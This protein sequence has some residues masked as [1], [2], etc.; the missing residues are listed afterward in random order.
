LTRLMLLPL[1]LLASAAWSRADSLAAQNGRGNRLYAEGRYA[2]A[3][4]AYLDAEVAHPGRP[5]VLY[6]LGNALLRQG[7]WDPA[8][9]ALGQ[10]A[11]KG[12]GRVREN[13]WFNTGNALF[14]MGRYQDSAGAFVQALRIDPDDR[15]AK[16][17]LEL[18]LARL[19]KPSSAA[20]GQ[21]PPPRTEAGGRGGMSREQALEMLD[22]LKVRE[23]EEQRRRLARAASPK[24]GARD[25]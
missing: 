25:W 12:D 9:R 15:D 21:K 5:E 8:L 24:A 4:K 2:D 6:N 22:A 1:F 10:A 3:E 13:A 23:T 19:G 16:R 14:A 7:K 20:A 11:A 18:A 17:N